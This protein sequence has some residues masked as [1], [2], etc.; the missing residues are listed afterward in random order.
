MQQIIK[1]GHLT[2]DVEKAI[3]NIRHD[4]LFVLTDE[5]THTHCFP[6]LAKIPLLREAGEIVI[7]AGDTNKTIENLGRV[8]QLL[9]GNGATRHSLLANLG[10]GMVTDLGGFAAATFKRGIR[11][12]N[13]PTTLLG[14]VDAAVGGKTGINFEGYKNEIGSFYPSESVIISS[15][16][17]H[18]LDQAAILSGYAEMIKHALIHSNEEWEEI[19]A[20]SFNETDYSKL[21]ELVFRSVKTKQN[22]VEKDPY[23]KNIRKA[24]NFGHTTGHAFESFAM[25]NGRPVPHGYAVAW[26]MIVELWLSHRLCGFPKEKLQRTVRFIRERYGAF[27]ITCDHYEALYEIARHDKKNIGDTI[28]FTLLGDIGDVRI[29]RTADKELVFEA[30]D[31]YRDSVGL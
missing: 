29:D 30:L 25:T 8:W 22:I 23:E 4:K 16:F 26:G 14:A 24:L 10:G 19:L 12:I 9:T 15:D 1:S 6:L 28:R 17:F 2:A 31:F 18:T 27:P 13:I 21:N 11:Y 20:Y 3:Q 7:P 5:N